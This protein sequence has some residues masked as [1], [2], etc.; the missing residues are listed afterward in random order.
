MKKLKT[1]LT[2]C[3]MMCLSLVLVACG[4]S[5]VEN[6]QSTTYVLTLDKIGQGT[7]EG[8]G[9]FSANTDITITAVCD[10]GFEFDGWYNGETFISNNNPYAFQMPAN[11]LTLTAQ[12]S[13]IDYYGLVANFVLEN[14]TY[15]DE[16]EAYYTVISPMIT[17]NSLYLYYNPI[18]QVFLLDNFKMTSLTISE[19]SKI[20]FEKD[21]ENIFIDLDIT[22]E[23]TTTSIIAT[24]NKNEM[25]SNITITAKIGVTEQM[26]EMFV[27]TRIFDRFIELHDYLI[28][29]LNIS[30]LD[31]GFNVDWAYVQE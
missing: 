24:F 14:G 25:E 17:G 31:L 4:N 9:N 23:S 8:C 15:D 12:F 1:I 22:V 21:L 28:E 27:E 6:T 18:S 7:V 20:Y 29:V 5:T 11:E 13:E 30:I 2:L 26:A 16:I 10:D 19:T 3:T